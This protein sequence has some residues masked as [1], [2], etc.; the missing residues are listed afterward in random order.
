[1][2]SACLIIVKQIILEKIKILFIV[3]NVFDVAS[4]FF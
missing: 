2:N 3:R 4:K 1:M